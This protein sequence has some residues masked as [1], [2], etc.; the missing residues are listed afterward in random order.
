M[1]DPETG[2]RRELVSGRFLTADGES[3]Y[4]QPPES[5]AE[6][7]GKGRVTLAVIQAGGSGQKNL[8]TT[9][10]D[11]YPDDDFMGDAVITFMVIKENDIYFS[12]GSYSG[13][14]VSF[15]GG[16]IVRVSKD[17]SSGEVV[18]EMT[19]FRTRYLL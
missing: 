6:A 18:A 10:P 12:Y 13:S 3:I 8:Y 2:E 19:A 1:I 17:G 9:G 16:K 15:S 11:L 14:S 7:A 4:Y 5:D